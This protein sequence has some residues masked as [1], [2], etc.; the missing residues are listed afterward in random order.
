MSRIGIDVGGTNSD[1]VVLDG[2]KVLAATKV[3][4]TPD[5]TGGIL[6]ALANVLAVPEVDMAAVDGV[7]IGTTHFINAVI[8]RRHL[9]RT[10]VLR[11]GLPV[12]ASLPP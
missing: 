2:T 5:V 11:I 6:A 4:T 8:Q 12:S 3:A 7:M 1:A 10:A 9:S